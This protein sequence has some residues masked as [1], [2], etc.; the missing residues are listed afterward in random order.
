M[1]GLEEIKRYLL[2]MQDM[3]EGYQR[4]IEARFAYLED[5]A[6]RLGRKDWLAILISSLLGLALQ[7]GLQG[8]STRDFL[9]FASRIV[10]EFLGGVLYL[11]Y[12]H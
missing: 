5:A 10:R 11:S 1:K 8:D 9:R 7:I 4:I 6:N 2:A 12:P 3:E